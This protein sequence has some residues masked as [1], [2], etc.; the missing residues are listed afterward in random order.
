LIYNKNISDLTEL[1]KT[2]PHVESHIV[3]GGSCIIA[4]G[5]VDGLS[6]KLATDI[7]G[8]GEEGGIIDVDEM[9]CSLFMCTP[10]PFKSLNTLLHK[11][12]QAEVV[13]GILG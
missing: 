1:K 9:S 13:K 2:R 5:V 10:T 4:H 7:I 8:D 12:H 11:E 6:L 3:S